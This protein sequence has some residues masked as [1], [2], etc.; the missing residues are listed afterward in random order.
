MIEIIPNWHPVFVHFTVALLSMSL[1][2]LVI[3]LLARSD[4]TRQ[5]SRIA[6]R[7]NFW[8]AVV[9]TF[10]T[11]FTGWLA[12]N[13]VNHDTPSHLAMTEHRNWALLTFGLLLLVAMVSWWKKMDVRVFS[14]GLCIVVGFLSV[15][16]W[17]GGELVYRYGLGVM[18]MPQVEG[19]GHGHAGHDHGDDSGQSTASHHDSGSAPADGH[20]IASDAPQQEA[21]EDKAVH[22]HK[23][24]ST[25][26]H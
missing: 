12:Y 10:V 25:H 8:L 21:V 4:T 7:W 14:I 19:E 23:D 15:T 26:Q 16:A 22:L 2:L 24:G 20:H 1:L 18:S 11:V 3:S 9:I 6:A 13:S 17:R 5:Q